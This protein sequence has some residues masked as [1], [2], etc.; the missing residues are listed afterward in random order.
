MFLKYYYEALLY[1]RSRVNANPLA[2]GSHFFGRLNRIFIGLWAITAKIFY[3]EM[4]NETQCT[5]HLVFR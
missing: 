1:C 2:V 3:F 5:Y 4:L